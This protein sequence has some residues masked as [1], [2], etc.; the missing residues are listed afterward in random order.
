MANS[1][2]ETTRAR[3]RKTGDWNGYVDAAL[4]RMHLQ[5]LSRAGVG[6]KS[7]A[8][9][10]DVSKTV[11]W[12]IFS[13]L[14]LR[15]RAR[16]VRKLLAVN[17]DC[18]ADASLVSAKRTWQLIGLLLEEGFTKCELARRLGYKNRALQLRK[19]YVLA[20]SAARIERLYRRLTT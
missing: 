18:R 10:A 13:G 17:T 1:N 7:A 3:A 9:A 12:Q 2:Y 8:A 14:K 16:T 4:A 5:K 19:D 20:R 15:C 11:V 6:Y